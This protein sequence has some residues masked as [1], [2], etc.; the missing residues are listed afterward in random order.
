MT[1]QHRQRPAAVLALGLLLGHGI[2]YLAAPFVEVRTG[3]II[4]PLT[5]EKT[6][7]ILFPVLLLMSVLVGFLPGMA[8]YQTDVAESLS[9]S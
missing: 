6:E 5:F 1:A 2:V 9:N 3:L 8:A 7:L 4:N